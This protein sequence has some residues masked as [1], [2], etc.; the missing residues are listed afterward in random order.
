[1]GV[2]KVKSY[3][4]LKSIVNG[5]GFNWALVAEVLNKTQGNV[6]AVARRKSKNIVIAKAIQAAADIPFE[7][8]FGMTQNEYEQATGPSRFTV[9]AKAVAERK[10]H[11]KQALSA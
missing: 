11:L 2:K 8:I 5:N 9:P 3:E 10:A 6:A 7:H 1:M 4:E